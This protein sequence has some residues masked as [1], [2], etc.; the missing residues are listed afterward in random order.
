M[1]DSRIR[2]LRAAVVTCSMF[3]LPATALASTEQPAPEGGEGAGQSEPLPR[4]AWEALVGS[5]VELTGRNADVSVGQ[6]LNVDESSATLV[7]ADGTVVALPLADVVAVRRIGPGES[8]STSE[9][10]ASEPPQPAVSEPQQ[11]AAPEANQANPE[12][13]Q[14]RSPMST[15]RGVYFAGMTGFGLP[16]SWDVYEGVSESYDGVERI[17]SPGFNIGFAIGGAPRPGL[18]LGFALDTNVGTAKYQDEYDSQDG[19]SGSGEAEGV[20]AAVGASL[21]VQAYIK[22]FFVRGGVGGMGLF[23]VGEENSSDGG[24][25]FDLGFGAHFPVANKV[26]LGFSIAARAAFWGYDNDDY[27]GRNYLVQPL[28]RFEVVAF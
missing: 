24:P 16:M 28:L 19:F 3:A 7:K 1:F 8:P 15:R 17:R 13:P 5:Q 18:V 6:L 25:G 21:F 9:P 11:P 2:L 12:G 4:S 10:A 27:K 26:A 20:G 22:N 23:F 14:S